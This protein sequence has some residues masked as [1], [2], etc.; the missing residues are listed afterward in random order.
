MLYNGITVGNIPSEVNLAGRNPSVTVSFLRPSALLLSQ[1][2]DY[3]GLSVNELA[4]LT[5]TYQ[6]WSVGMAFTPQEKIDLARQLL[7]GYPA[8]DDALRQRYATI[9]VDY[10]ARL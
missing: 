9:A 4:S 5:E 2:Q 6:K 8:L 3:T 10:S 7:A 1:L